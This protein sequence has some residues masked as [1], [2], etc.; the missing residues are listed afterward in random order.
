MAGWQVAVMLAFRD[1]HQRAIV[2]KHFIQEYGD[3]HGARLRHSVVA[4]PGAIILMPLPDIAIKLS[5]GVNFILMHVELFAEQL[6]D[7]LD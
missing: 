5:F 4:Q 3:I 6:L 7:R 2:G 1:Q